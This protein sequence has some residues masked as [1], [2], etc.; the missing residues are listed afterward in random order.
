VSERCCIV[1]YDQGI[2]LY[3]GATLRPVTDVVEHAIEHPLRKGAMIQVVTGKAS[4]ALINAG[5]IGALLR[6]WTATIEI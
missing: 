2:V 5:G 4:E 3:C 1:L 6:A